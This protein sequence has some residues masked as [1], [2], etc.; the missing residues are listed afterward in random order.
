MPNI[1]WNEIKHRALLFSREWASASSEAADKQTFWNDFFNIFGISRRVVATFESPVKRRTGSTGFIDLLWP[2]K[3]II[4]HKS[5]GASL[6]AAQSQAFGYIQNLAETGRHDEI[7]RYVLLCDFR[8]FALYDLEP[9]DQLGLPLFSDLRFHKFPEFS[10]AELR[11]HVTDFAFIPGYTVHKFAPQDPANLKAVALMAD[12]HD[13]LKA[14]GYIGHDLE[15][16]LVRIL[17]C[18]F[19]E[20]TGIFEPDAFRL[21][22]ENRTQRDGSDLG[23]RIAQLFHVL[24][25][26]TENRQ[27]NLDEALAEFPYVN[28]QLFSEHIGFAEFNMPMRE[29][30]LRCS[31]FDWSRISP[32]IFGALFQ[33]VMT[34]K[35]RR[36]IGAHYTSER[37]ILKVIKP[38]FLD[39]L[40]AEFEAAKADRSTRRAARLDELRGRLARL[41]L[42]DP[43]CGCGNFLVIAYRELRQ[44]ELDILIEQHGTQQSLTLDEVARLSSLDVNQFYGIEIEEW[45]ARIAEVALWLVD[46]QGNMRIHEA[47]S[48]PC[49]RLPLR[50]SP[51][52]H[53]ANALLMDW[54]NLLPVTECSYVLG[55]PPFVGKSLM[56]GEQKNDMTRVIRE[57]GGIAGA[58]VLD[59]VTAWYIKAAQYINNTAIEAA[60]V[61]TNSI[62]QGEQ[63]GILW[64]HLFSK[65]Q[66]AINFAYQTFAWTSEASGRAH[67]HVVIAGF[68]Q[69]PRREKQIFIE[70][71]DSDHL[72]SVSAQ[73]ISPYLVAAGNTTLLKRSSPI[74]AV[75]EIIFGNMPNDGG[76]LLLTAD[77]RDQLLANE[78]D[79]APYL[80]QFLG[81]E[82]FLNG[83][84][85]YC[86]WLVGAKPADLQSLPMV[87]QR[88]EGV[89]QHRIESR[90]PT[91][92]ELANI[93]SLFGEIRQPATNY[94]AVPEVSSERR[95]YIPL[96][97]LPPTVICSNLMKFIPDATL[98]HFGVLTSV[99]H[100]AWVKRV[101]GRLES[102]FRYS[103]TLVY[104]NY[105][106]PQDVPESEQ[107]K[108]E[109]LAQAVLNARAL[110]PESTL[111]AL[112][113]PLL[114]PPELLKAHQAL[115][116]AVDRC[117]RPEPFPDDQARVEYLFT[118]YEQLTAPLLP[119]TPRARR[120]RRQ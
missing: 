29:A 52:I 60:F 38:L 11:D 78:P 109:Q 4:E 23:A 34:D 49:L 50:N 116:R 40:R 1:A 39:S 108:V 9:E 119:A 89:R 20:D 80:R 99:M 42:L 32:A 88:I 90:R 51:H 64:N 86:L 54:N 102:R 66:L 58:G 98:F 21:Y 106:W 8:R 71:D 59:Y 113:D 79:T 70:A 35:E 14:G 114:M 46:H 7:P 75:P 77:E 82:E 61:S 92:K 41:R 10:L 30:L 91:T 87:M 27:T 81:A 22:I 68:S 26:P 24:N 95:T 104:N 2:G 97:F 105:P 19:A 15:R 67:V 96:A 44:L 85:R 120:R 16:F 62:T 31:R 63:P 65:F 101:A 76:N 45:P 69:H 74:S 72:T 3:I 17:F 84:E 110:Y 107:S 12:L 73:N 43:A 56:S 117:Y 6:E 111:A 47:F 55:N 112:Y 83:G 18:L 28:G 5:L 118:L 57:A 93:P 94:V 48:Q 100:M 103:N 25:T 36:H 115:D 33:E 13:K 53:V 37:D